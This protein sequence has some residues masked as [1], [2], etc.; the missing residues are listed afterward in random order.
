MMTTIRTADRLTVW[1][2]LKAVREAC[3]VALA[4]SASHPELET[5]LEDIRLIVKSSSTDK[6]RAL[7]LADPYLWPSA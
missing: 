4:G 2:N 5:L 3:L 1:E 6:A 7:F